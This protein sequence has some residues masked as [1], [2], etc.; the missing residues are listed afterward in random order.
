SVLEVGPIELG[1][2]AIAAGNL[3]VSRPGQDTVAAYDIRTRRLAWRTRVDVPGGAGYVWACDDDVC[4]RHEADFTVLD[5]DTGQV[6]DVRLDELGT[7]VGSNVRVDYVGSDAFGVGPSSTAVVTGR[8]GR[9]IATI[10]N[11]WPVTG[12][13]A[14]ESTLL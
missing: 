1:M 8:D 12:M 5:G 7:G 10:D 14:G 2:A 3:A 4:M 9:E 11:V 13:G 6:L